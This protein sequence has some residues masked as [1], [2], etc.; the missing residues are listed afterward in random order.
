[1]TA[2]GQLPNLMTEERNR[3][4]SR[5]VR[6]AGRRLLRFVRARVSSEAEAEDV[7]QDVWQQLVTTLD[8]GPIEHIGAWLYTV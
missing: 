3:R 8:E 4:A 6:D 7:L 5:I 2:A 1:M